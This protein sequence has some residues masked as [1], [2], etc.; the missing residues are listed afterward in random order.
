MCYVK[1]SS[2][3]SYSSLRCIELH[4]T[5]VQYCQVLMFIQLC[6]FRLPKCICNILAISKGACLFNKDFLICTLWSPLSSKS[7]KGVWL[8]FKWLRLHTA[9]F[10]VCLKFKMLY[11]CHQKE[12]SINLFLMLSHV[13][14]VVLGGY[15]FANVKILLF[16]NCSIYTDIYCSNCLY[17]MKFSVFTWNKRINTA[18]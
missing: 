9:A 6:T 3:K 8:T 10:W 15:C 7:S 5:P 18:D 16:L 11:F 4:K 13:P 12:I 1:N 17:N 14:D 2:Q